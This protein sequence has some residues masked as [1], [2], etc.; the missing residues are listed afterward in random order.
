MSNRPRKP[1]AWRPRVAEFGP[2]QS[3]SSLPARLGPRRPRCGGRACAARGGRGGARRAW[4]G[5]RVVQRAR[6]GGLGRFWARSKCGLGR[7]AGP[8]RGLR[9]GTLF[10]PARGAGGRFPEPRSRVARPR[11]GESARYWVASRPGIP[12]WEGRKGGGPGGRGQGVSNALER[13]RGRPKAVHSFAGNFR[14]GRTRRRNYGR[15]K[16]VP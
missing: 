8:L 16:A 10:S 5:S 15:P 9:A 7:T 2:S 13:V 11:V 14:K 12:M 6:L 1:P 4:A 3:Q